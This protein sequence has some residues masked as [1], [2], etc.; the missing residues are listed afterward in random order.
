MIHKSSLTV[1]TDHNR[2]RLADFEDS[3]SRYHVALALSCLVF[4]PA[5]VWVYSCGK[6]TKDDG[7]H[8]DLYGLTS[9]HPMSGLR[10]PYHP[11]VVTCLDHMKSTRAETRLSYRKIVV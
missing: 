4:P 9:F 8:N 11:I 7:M 5:R 6:V 3:L 2:S 1:S 10:L